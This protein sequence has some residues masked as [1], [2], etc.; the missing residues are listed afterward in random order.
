MCFSEKTL[1]RRL[2]LTCF[3]HNMRTF[4]RLRLLLTDMETK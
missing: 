4:A 3:V 1:Q 2:R